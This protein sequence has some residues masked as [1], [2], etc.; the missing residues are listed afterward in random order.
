MM[1]L[2]G[3]LNWKSVFSRC[4]YEALYGSVVLWVPRSD[5]LV[6]LL[7]V[8]VCCGRGQCAA[9]GCSV[10]LYGWILWAS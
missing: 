8:S 4:S 1:C 2:Y 7:G 9:G 3:V 5:G 6:F 10:G